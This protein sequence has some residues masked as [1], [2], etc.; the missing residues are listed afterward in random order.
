MGAENSFI[1]PHWLR[2]KLSPER[3]RRLMS[4]PAWNYFTQSIKATRSFESGI[5][6]CLILLRYTEDNR[7]D[8]GGGEYEHN[9]VLLYHFLLNLLDRTD[10][11]GEYLSLWENLRKTTQFFN[12]Y[13]KD[14]LKIHGKEI[15]P[16]ILAD[17]GDS[18]RV[19]FLYGILDRRQVIQG[20]HA[21]QLSGKRV[22]RHGRQ[23]GLS[24][25][26]I[27]QR[28]ERVTARFMYAARTA[29][30]ERK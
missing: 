17:D 23:E 1:V 3:Y 12:T 10:R 29:D 9:L 5:D 6:A 4:Y 7:N 16:F 8:M 14:S 18:V 26:E 20:K 24:A 25:S 28:L 19:H 11:W 21:K 27:R 15:E 13:A 2:M 30:G 22:V